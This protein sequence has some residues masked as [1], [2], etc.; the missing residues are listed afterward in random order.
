[1]SNTMRINTRV[2]VELTKLNKNFENILKIAIVTVL[3][4][5]DLYNNIN[6]S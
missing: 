2:R 4:L 1:M 3:L 5:R 6:L